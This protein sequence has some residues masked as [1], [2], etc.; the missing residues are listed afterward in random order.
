M[1]PP[2]LRVLARAHWPES[3]D[4]GL[5]PLAGFTASTF[6]PLVAETAERCLRAHYGPAP[7]PGPS[8]TALL[9]TSGSGDRATAAAIDAAAASPQRVPPLLFFQSNPNAILG[10]LAAR[11]RLTGPVLATSPPRPAVPGEVPADALELA[12]LL[13]ADGDADQVLLIAAEQ[14]DRTADGSAQTDHA[15][16]LLLTRA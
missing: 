16:A 5:P 7:G 3:A 6:N 2:P 11:W 13:L 14:A 8:R 9:L 12:E 4:D 1:P 15:V 10:H